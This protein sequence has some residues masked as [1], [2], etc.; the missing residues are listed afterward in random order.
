MAEKVRVYEEK[1]STP[2]WWW[3]LPLLL[4]LAALVWYFT[5]RHTPVAATPAAVTQGALPDLG[6]VHFDTDQATL[7]PASQ[8]T[9][10]R[11]AQAL[12]ANPNAHLRLEGYTD[13]SGTLATNAPLSEQRTYAV[14]NYLKGKGIDGNRLTG[15]GFGPANPVD[16]NAT[17][18]GKADNRRV[19]LFSQQ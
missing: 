1:K 18:Q 12:K 3:L 17:A 5:M 8:A 14:A 19:E 10:D 7:T 2:V 4:L 11:A 6:T 9:L 16:T 13:S 15:G